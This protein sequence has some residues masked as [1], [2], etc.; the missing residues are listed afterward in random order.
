ML[1]PSRDFGKPKPTR[2]STNLLS[3]VMFEEMRDTDMFYVLIAKRV[4]EGVG[5]P[6]AVVSLVKELGT[7][8]LRS[9]WRVYHLY[10]IFNIRLI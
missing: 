3:L 9:C 1:L 7:C 8:F 4:S 2:D 5:I 6:K 10:A